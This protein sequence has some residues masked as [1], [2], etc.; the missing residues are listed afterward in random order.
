MTSP[1]STGST[2]APPTGDRVD[3]RNRTA[4]AAVTNGP[5][6]RAAGIA[7]AFKTHRVGTAPL[8]CRQF[9]PPRRAGQ[10]RG[11]V[12]Q[13]RPRRTT[14]RIQRAVTLTPYDRLI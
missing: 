3:L 4:T 12:R 1:V 7:M 6:S 2:Y 5:G 11:E 13:W 8:A 14:R 9:R 10:S